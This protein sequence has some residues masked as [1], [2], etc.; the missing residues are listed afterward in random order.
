[1]SSLIDSG[2]M[3]SHMDDIIDEVMM[4]SSS[5]RNNTYQAMLVSGSL[6]H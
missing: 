6:E 5:V 1:M 2:M 3:S 4:M